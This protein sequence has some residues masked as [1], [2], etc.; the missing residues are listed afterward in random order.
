[1]AEGLALPYTFLAGGQNA[2]FA[3]QQNFQT[4]V[5]FINRRLLASGL[6]TFVPKAASESVTSSITLQDDDDLSF[7]TEA[8]AVYA[9]ESI[10]IVSSASAIPDFQFQWVE[11]DGTWD[12]RYSVGTATS[13]INEGT[14]AAAVSLAAA[15]GIPLHFV[16]SIVAG[17]TGGVF[18]L[19]WAQNTS[20]ATATVVELGSWLSYRKL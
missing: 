14:A 12:F 15:T 10:L 5:T 20:D 3:A 19:Q 4:I 18:K 1:M 16:G 8:S 13:A 11:A 6:T 2:E 7:T 17:A 9:F